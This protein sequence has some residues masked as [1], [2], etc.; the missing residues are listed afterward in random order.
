MPKFTDGLCVDGDEGGG[1][2]K[3]MNADERKLFEDDR[4]GAGAGFMDGVHG[5]CGLGA[6]GALKIAEYDDFDGCIFFA[7]ARAT[8]RF[9]RH[10]FFETERRVLGQHKGV[11][12]FEALLDVKCEIGGQNRSV[13]TRMSV[14]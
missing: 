8:V 4:H 14:L 11:I 1:G 9:K 12:A 10:R 6:V 13:M 3:R 7:Q 5:L 2:G